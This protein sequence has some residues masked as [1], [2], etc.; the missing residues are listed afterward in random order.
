LAIQAKKASKY[1]KL[2]QKTK[3][4]WDDDKFGSVTPPVRQNLAQK[5]LADPNEP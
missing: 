5:N 1:A 4:S 3:E 2:F